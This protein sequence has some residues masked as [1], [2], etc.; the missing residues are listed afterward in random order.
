MMAFCCAWIAASPLWLKQAH[1]GKCE[2]VQHCGLCGGRSGSCLQ[3]RHSL[4]FQPELLQLRG[5]CRQATS[6]RACKLK[7]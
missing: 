6:I 4:A 7:G 2:A 3:R 5:P 1:L